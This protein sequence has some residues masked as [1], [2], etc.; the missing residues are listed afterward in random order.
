[1]IYLKKLTATFLLF[2]TATLNLLAQQAGSEDIEM[3][4]R[5]REDGKIWVVVG[6]IALIFAGIIIY[7]VRIDSKVSKLEKKIN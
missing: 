1:M 2:L 7:L 4:D 5:L 3:A 6:V